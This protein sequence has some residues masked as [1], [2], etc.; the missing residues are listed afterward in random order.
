M[1]LSMNE[2]T[3]EGKSEEKEA[4]HSQ[5]STINEQSDRKHEGELNI[6]M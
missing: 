2:H 4:E 6:C 3:I 5:N 1:T